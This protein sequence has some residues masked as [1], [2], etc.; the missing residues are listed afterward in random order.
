MGSMSLMAVIEDEAIAP[1]PLGFVQRAI[2]GCENFSLGNGRS[3]W[4]EGD[5]HTDRD[6]THAVRPARMNN[7]E[8]LD[9]LHKSFC[10]AGCFQVS[11]VPHGEGELFSTEP[12]ADQ[13]RAGGHGCKHSPD[14]AKAIV[15]RGMPQHVV[16]ELE[17]VDV[18]HHQGRG[19]IVVEPLVHALA[20][21][22][23]IWKAGQRIHPGEILKLLP[24]SLGRFGFQ[25]R[26]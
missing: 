20:E 24:R 17:M 21:E 7:T 10:E 5:A 16:E 23:P 19:T 15:T 6:D 3:I 26:A 25:A 9:S 13:I 11:D 1:S 8:G 12:R 2:G 18:D 14:A 4:L 22:P